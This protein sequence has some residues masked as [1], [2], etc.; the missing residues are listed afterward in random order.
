M[1]EIIVGVDES[2]GAA[3]ALRWAVREAAVHDWPV[4]AVLVWHY[5]DQHLLDSDTFDPAYDEG[6]AEKV[7]AAAVARA[8]GEEAAATIATTTVVDLA[9]QGLIEQ[10]AGAQLLVVGARGLGGFASLLLGSVSNHCLHYAP[11]P[12]AVVRTTTSCGPTAHQRVVVGV[13]GSATAQR[14]LHWALDEARLRKATVEVVHA[15]RPPI[16]GGPFTV[17]PVDPTI[18]EQ[19]A[20]DVVENA[21]AGED[22][23]GLDLRRTL[24]CGGATE[25]L[26]H[27]AEDADLVVVG[28]RGLGA[29]QRLLLG[30]VSHQVAHHVRCPVV[31]IPS[32]QPH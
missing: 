3:A 8:V 25:A 21:L 31:V 24:V 18:S 32:G 9:A 2:D 6:V 1:E 22:T 16:V 23:E 26:L 13:D 12:V 11:C 15:W 10:A 17:V 4:R 30:S 19:A 28:S 20:H 27:A 7:L 14:A 5:L 29:F